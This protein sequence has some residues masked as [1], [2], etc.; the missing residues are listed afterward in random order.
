MYTI[1]QQM[2]HEIFVVA[3]SSYFRQQ[4]VQVQRISNDN[5]NGYHVVPNHVH[6]ESNGFPGIEDS[7][8]TSNDMKYF[9]GDDKENNFLTLESDSEDAD[10]LTFALSDPLSEAEVD[11]QRQCFDLSLDSDSDSEMEEFEDTLELQLDDCDD[12]DD[13]YCSIQEQQCE[14]N[15][16]PSSDLL[17]CKIPT[18]SLNNL[19]DLDESNDIYMDLP[20]HDDLSSATVE[21]LAVSREAMQD[22]D[23]KDV[24]TTSSIFMVDQL[25]AAT[26]ICYA[27]SQ[28]VTNENPASPLNVTIKKDLLDECKQQCI[29]DSSE[30]HGSIDVRENTSKCV[31]SAAVLPEEVH[32]LP[33]TMENVS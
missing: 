5:L 27:P 16:K 28:N 15:T 11:S 14:N 1:I 23:V 7:L 13:L 26:A 18:L 32:N 3:K 30:T 24:T 8:Y 25:C 10:Q 4:G 2:L 6:S 12:G 29:C 33:M 20:S 19:T 17:V 21:V 9:S 31:A 22:H